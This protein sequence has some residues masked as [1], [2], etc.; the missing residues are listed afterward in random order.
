MMPPIIFGRN[1]RIAL[2]DTLI[3]QHN[4]PELVAVLAHEIGHYKKKHII[5]GMILSIL[6]YSHPPLL[7]RMEAIEKA[8]YIR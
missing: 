5:W 1:K 8:G 4:V 3:A 7:Q 2:F 6:Y